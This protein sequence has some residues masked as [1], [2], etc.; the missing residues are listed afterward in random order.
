MSEIGGSAPEF[1]ATLTGPIVTT[2]T[3]KLPGGTTA[4]Q[5]IQD[6]LAWLP[7]D[8][9]H[10]PVA[11]VG[12]AGSGTCG[13]FEV[14]SATLARILGAKAI[15]DPQGV[16]AVDILTYHDLQDVFDPTNVTYAELSAGTDAPDPDC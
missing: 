15:G 4:L 2:L 11:E 6:V 9:E 14:R 7:K 16:V 10:S 12:S 1:Q 3:E 8:S 5:A 13:V